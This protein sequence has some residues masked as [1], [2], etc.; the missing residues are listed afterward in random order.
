MVTLNPE[1]L[2]QWQEGQC[3]NLRYKFYDLQPG[4]YCIDLGSY[5]R[6]WA[7]RMI[8]EY[9]VE[10]DCF[11]ALENRAAWIRDGFIEMGGQYYY[12]SMF[13]E[14]FNQ[15]RCYDIAPFLQ[16]E[17]AVMKVNIEGGEY[18]VLQHIIN[19]GLHKN[20]R[21]LQV[22][23]HQVDGFTWEAWYETIARELS[24]THRLTWRY[25]FCWENFERL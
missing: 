1:S 14:G 21:N 13:T 19:L 23:F 18:Q 7:N 2:K 5:Q 15:Y 10:V 20:I 24:K 25:P 16:R 11:D 8:E 3:E 12:T 17:V 9:K 6:E 4:E 22:Q